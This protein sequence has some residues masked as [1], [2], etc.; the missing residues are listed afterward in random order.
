MEKNVNQAKHSI[1]LFTLTSW[2]LHP[3]SLFSVHV[4][5]DLFARRTP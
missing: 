2:D 5:F 4:F 3:I 1:L